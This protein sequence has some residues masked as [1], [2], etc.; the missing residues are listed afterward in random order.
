MVDSQKA[1]TFLNAFMSASVQSTTYASNKLSQ[2][3]TSTPG[4]K[5]N[6][7]P[8]STNQWY[9]K[10]TQLKYMVNSQSKTVLVMYNSI[11]PVLKLER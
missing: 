9:V 6:S 4:A 1:H 2:E 11:T 3:T 10:Q 7:S 5:A 8:V